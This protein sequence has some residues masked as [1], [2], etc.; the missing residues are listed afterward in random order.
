MFFAA[1]ESGLA[2]LILLFVFTQIIYPLLTEQPLLPMFRKRQR[3][4]D[5][6][7]E[8]KKARG[9]DIRLS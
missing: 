7:E 3:L 9:Q 8:V 1:L 6:L 5:Q 2:I 4:L